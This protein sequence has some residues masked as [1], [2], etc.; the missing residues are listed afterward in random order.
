[1]RIFHECEGRIEKSVPTIAVWHHKACRV[2]TNGDLERRIF[3]SH[4]HRNNG[5]FF[6]LTTA[7]FYPRVKSQISL[8]GVQEI[9][10]HN[11]ASESK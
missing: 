10:F 1:M 3:L 11:E 9:L 4:S 8:S 7:F 5:F 6:L 2:M